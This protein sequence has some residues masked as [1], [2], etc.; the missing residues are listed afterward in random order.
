[1]INE[2]GQV[3]IP[4][5]KTFPLC[6]SMPWSVSI[7]IPGKFVK[8]IVKVQAVKRVEIV[9]HISA[10]LTAIATFITALAVDSGHRFRASYCLAKSKN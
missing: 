8:N 2:T 9:M 3:S 10:G 1:M 6:R 5:S 4:G 7:I